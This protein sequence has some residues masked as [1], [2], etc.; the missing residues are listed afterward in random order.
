[1]PHSWIRRNVVA[2]SLASFF[3]DLSHEVCTAVLPLYLKAAGLGPQVLGILE[4]V[5]NLLFNSGKLVGGIFGYF[6]RRKKP[7]AASGY[8]VTT[9]FTAAIS[10]TVLPLLLVV[11]RGI[12]WFARG[13]R[14]PLRDDL[15]ARSVDREHY[16]KAFGLERTG[17][18]LGAVAGP[19][20]AGVL[21]LA[22]WS[23]ESIILMGVIPG[24]LAASSIF[25]FVKEKP[26]AGNPL[27]PSEGRDWGGEAFRFVLPLRFWILFCGVI[28]F[29]LG[30]YSRSF[31]IY[32]VARHVDTRGLP[33]DIF[34]SLP[35]FLY[36]SHNVV[37]ALV[38][39]AAG[40]LADRTSRPG[41]LALGY[42]LGSITT[43]LL[44]GFSDYLAVLALAMIFSGA[45]L[46]IEEALERA[47]VAEVLPS[48]LRSLGFGVV[49]T[50]AAVGQAAASLYVGY[51]LEKESAAVAFGLAA[52]FALAATIWMT[53][54]A[55]WI[56][57]GR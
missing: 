54:F 10:L 55:L 37:S 26:L 25:F 53:I 18:M 23:Y 13:F 15:L 35:V 24:L 56:H 32:L 4:G 51:L 34:V 33:I 48:R 1:M 21:L 17:D 41:T 39:Y 30:N 38:P 50:A 12:A 52:A 20:L 44:A 6:V 16:G 36:T 14:S 28:L 11:F 9:I 22:A 46:A 57:E 2:I 49:G 45:S 3:S 5:A 47:T 42:L 31:L 19:A 43:I 27:P 40:M 29:S 7:W 8:L